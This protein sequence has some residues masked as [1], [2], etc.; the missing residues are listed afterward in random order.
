MEVE[1]DCIFASACESYSHSNVSRC[2]DNEGLGNNPKGAKTHHSSNICLYAVPIGQYHMG[3]FMSISF[4]CHALCQVLM[5]S[6]DHTDLADYLR[7]TLYDSSDPF[8][9]ALQRPGSCFGGRKTQRMT[10]MATGSMSSRSFMDG[11]LPRK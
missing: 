7:L 4:D 6:T 3:F 8:A 9:G 11:S 1:H 5:D 10:S 2:C